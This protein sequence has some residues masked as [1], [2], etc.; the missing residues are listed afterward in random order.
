MFAWT[1]VMVERQ[2]V[3]WS[4]LLRGRLKYC[5]ASAR[6]EVRTQTPYISM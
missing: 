1:K 6:L 3:I 5:R 2:E 4:R